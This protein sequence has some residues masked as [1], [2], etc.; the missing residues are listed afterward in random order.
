MSNIKWNNVGYIFAGIAVT[1]FTCVIIG[2][3]FFDLNSGN[4]PL[5][6]GWVFIFLE[7]V[8]FGIYMY[9]NWNR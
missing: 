7:Y 8:S 3:L 5:I 9:K 6:I 2:N 4:W 1:I